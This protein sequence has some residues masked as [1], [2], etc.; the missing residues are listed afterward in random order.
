M[1]ST[2][3]ASVFHSLV[4]DT[5]LLLSCGGIMWER[6]FDIGFWWWCPLGFAWCALGDEWSWFS[7][8]LSADM[9]GMENWL[10][11]NAAWWIPTLSSAPWWWWKPFLFGLL[12]LSFF[13]LPFRLDDAFEEKRGS[14]EDFSNGLCLID[15]IIGAIVKLCSKVEKR[16]FSSP[17][18]RRSHMFSLLISTSKR[19]QMGIR[20]HPSLILSKIWLRC[21]HVILNETQRIFNLPLLFKNA[22]L[23]LAMLW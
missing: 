21:L 17:P 1:Y 9:F 6:N 5:S 13:L 14:I 2:C 23:P 19:R 16:W 22:F 20:L 8:L 4:E 15:G 11:D 18:K 3:F 7:W 10:C 12:L